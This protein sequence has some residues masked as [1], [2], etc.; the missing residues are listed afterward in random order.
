MKI[1]YGIIKMTLNYLGQLIFL[2]F[3]VKILTKCKKIL[4]IPRFNGIITK[5]CSIKQKNC[6]PEIPSKPREKLLDS[7]ITVKWQI[8]IPGSP[9]SRGMKIAGELASL[10]KF[11]NQQMSYQGH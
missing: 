10:G 4:L 6:S 5:D 1:K 9:N 2:T 3:Q 8:A 7:Q 11:T